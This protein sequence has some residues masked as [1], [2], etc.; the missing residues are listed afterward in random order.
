MITGEE[1]KNARH[2]IGKTQ[3]QLADETDYSLRQIS[4]FEN[5][6]YLKRYDKVLQLIVALELYEPVKEEKVDM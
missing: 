4:R 5:D 3:E 1:I 6:K 2:K